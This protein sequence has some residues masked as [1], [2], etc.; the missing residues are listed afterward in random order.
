MDIVELDD[1]K[2]IF[3]TLCYADSTSGIDEKCTPSVE[4]PNVA[5]EAKV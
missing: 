3:V 4:E 2:K 1:R 5:K